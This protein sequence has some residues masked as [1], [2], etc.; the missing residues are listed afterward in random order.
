M[1]TLQGWGYRPAG[2][3]VAAVVTLLVGAAVA[4]GGRRVSVHV[5]DEDA[6]A[7]I[8]VLSH[9]PCAPGDDQPTV[10][11]RIGTLDGVLSCGTDAAPD[12]R[13]VWALLDV[14]PTASPRPVSAAPAP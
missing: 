4:D 14:G 13:R 7:A 9:R 8:A 5:A 1:S 12:G 10:L 6:V 3:S 11:R 2:D